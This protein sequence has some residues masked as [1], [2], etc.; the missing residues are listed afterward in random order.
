MAFVCE[1]QFVCVWQGGG[2]VLKCNFTGELINGS[3]RRGGNFGFYLNQLDRG[4]FGVSEL[5]T[6]K[7]RK[8][9]L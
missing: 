7:S 2:I 1:L 6:S 3:H 9:Y 4:S 8:Q 5:I